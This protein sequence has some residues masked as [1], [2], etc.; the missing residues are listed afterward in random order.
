MNKIKFTNYNDFN[1]PQT[2]VLTKNNEEIHLV[3]IK[4]VK[5]YDKVSTKSYIHLPEVYKINNY[6]YA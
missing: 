6:Y 3:L 1:I 5:Y 2:V 4:Y